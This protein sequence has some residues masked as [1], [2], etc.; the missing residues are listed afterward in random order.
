MVLIY[1]EI[2]RLDKKVKVCFVSDQEAFK[3]ENSQL[4]GVTLTSF[5][6]IKT[7]AILQM[8]I[9]CVNISRDMKV[10]TS[11]DSYVL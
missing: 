5:Q 11:A 4:C 2:K 6:F 3:F 9:L 7:I 8:P 10:L 1:I